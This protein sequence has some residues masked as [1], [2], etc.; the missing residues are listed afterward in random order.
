MAERPKIREK[1]IDRQKKKGTMSDRRRE[2]QREINGVL[3]FVTKSPIRIFMLSCKR[4]LLQEFTDKNFTDNLKKC[5]LYILELL[6]KEKYL[7]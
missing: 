3:L 7:K 6:T 1:I 4:C 2:R 5:R